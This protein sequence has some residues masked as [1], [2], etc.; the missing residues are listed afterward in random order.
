MS[1][2]RFLIINFILV[3]ILPVSVI[4]FF[5]LGLFLVFFEKISIQLIRKNDLF[6]VPYT[7]TYA[8]FFPAIAFEGTAVFFFKRHVLS[9]ILAF[10]VVCCCVVS[11]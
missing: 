9:F 6:I 5:S 1:L 10:C 4:G 7:I 3:A 8:I 2:K 11:F